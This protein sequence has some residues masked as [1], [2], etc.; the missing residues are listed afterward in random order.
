MHGMHS[1]HVYIQCV[2]TAISVHSGSRS[3]KFIISAA[4]KNASPP[5]LFCLDSSLHLPLSL[6]GNER[7]VVGH[8]STNIVLQRP[9]H[10]HLLYSAS[11]LFPAMPGLEFMT[12]FLC[13][14]SNMN[15]EL[16]H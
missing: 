2:S 4:G 14:E 10:L 8:R 9:I 3:A 16:T 11:H 6:C 1:S 12:L 15:G 13:L 7:P 5:S